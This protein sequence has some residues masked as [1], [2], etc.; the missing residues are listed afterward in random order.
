MNNDENKELKFS[1]IYPIVV[2]EAQDV[3]VMDLP[4]SVR[5]KNV[6]MRN[7]VTTLSAILNLNISE[8]CRFYRKLVI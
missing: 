7:H 8:L 4:F 5:L 1:D 6:L 2:S 3:A